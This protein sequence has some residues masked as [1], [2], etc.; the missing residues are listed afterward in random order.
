MISHLDFAAP[1]IPTFV[2]SQWVKKVSDVPVCK[3]DGNGQ[4]CIADASQNRLT[5]PRLLVR[6]FNCVLT[7]LETAPTPSCSTFTNRSCGT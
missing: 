5:T 3:Y 1:N 4:V 2:D 6:A 7:V